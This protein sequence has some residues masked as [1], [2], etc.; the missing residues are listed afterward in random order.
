MM[1]DGLRGK[2]PDSSSKVR[3]SSGLAGKKC[4]WPLLMDAVSWTRGCESWDRISW[5]C[6][7]DIGGHQVMHMVFGGLK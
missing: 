3:G 4:T 6:L 1:V 5:R 7:A 2:F